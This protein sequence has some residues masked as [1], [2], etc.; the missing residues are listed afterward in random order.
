[1]ILALAADVNPMVVCVRC[2]AH[3]TA[4]V[5]FCPACGRDR[6]AL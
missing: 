1:V 3:M 5:R 4:G 6:V 2:A